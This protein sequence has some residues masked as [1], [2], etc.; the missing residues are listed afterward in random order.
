MHSTVACQN[1]VVST[2]G[3]LVVVVCLLVREYPLADSGTQMHV[4]KIFSTAYFFMFSFFQHCT[5]GGAVRELIQ[6]AA[7]IRGAF[8]FEQWTCQ[9][10]DS[11]EQAK[12]CER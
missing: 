1:V 6:W 11:T 10:V 7:M 9:S 2:G 4:R 5:A 12:G 8:L 3:W